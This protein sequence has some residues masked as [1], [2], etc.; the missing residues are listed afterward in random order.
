M[1]ETGASSVTLVSFLLEY[2]SIFRCQS[3]VEVYGMGFCGTR[4]ILFCE[5]KYC[6]YAVN[7]MASS[8]SVSILPVCLYYGSIHCAGTLPSIVYQYTS[9][10]YRYAPG[11][12]TR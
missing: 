5:S 7:P 9:I 4:V 8:A 10:M 2:R 1:Y 11:V 6:S 12:Y 3:S